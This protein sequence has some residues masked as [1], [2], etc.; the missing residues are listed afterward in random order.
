[1]FDGTAFLDFLVQ[2]AKS[3]RVTLQPGVPEGNATQMPA[4][5]RELARITAGFV[6]NTKG[7]QEIRWDG[8][9]ASSYLQSADSNSWHMDIGQDGCGNSWVLLIEPE[10]GEPRE[11]LWASH[12]APVIL[13]AEDSFDRFC[14]E[15]IADTKAFV[16]RIGEHETAI[17][18]AK[19]KGL[20]FEDAM[21]SHDQ[22]L[23]EFADGLDDSWRIFDL[24]P[25][26]QFRGFVRLA[27]DE[28]RKHKTA[29]VFA[30]RSVEPPPTTPWWRAL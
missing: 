27:I 20:S 2:S 5:L 7:E 21:A 30:H 6:V 9:L 4:G 10:S 18:R 12:D 25:A 3:G 16:K 15:F 1:M 29:L 17:Y 23:C 28:I 24:R 8:E 11:V 22:V 13:V 14:R 26:Q 19:P